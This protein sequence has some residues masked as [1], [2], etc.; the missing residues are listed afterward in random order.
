MEKKGS[1]LLCVHLS[2][3]PS[4]AVGNGFGAGMVNHLD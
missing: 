2:D 1:G 4:V 3:Q